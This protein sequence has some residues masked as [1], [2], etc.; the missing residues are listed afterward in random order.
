MLTN[1][2]IIEGA[3]RIANV[4]TILSTGMSTIEQI[5]MA[6]EYW[7]N[8][9]LGRHQDR[10]ALLHCTSTY[11]C[12]P[13]ELNLNMIHTLK[14]RFA[15]PIGYSGHETG[16]APTLA[17]VA[18]GAKIIERHITLDRAMWG[19]DHAASVE[20]QGLRRLVRDIRLI[21]QAMG[22]GT[23]RVYDSE[24]PSLKKLRGAYGYGKQS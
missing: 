4:T 22:D 1:N 17:A 6:V 19:S 3:A 23:K 7:D 24:I 15:V 12:P 11:P 21:E 18:L 2:A 9:C 10:L 20:P 14:E 13:E 16:L 5:E 8:Q